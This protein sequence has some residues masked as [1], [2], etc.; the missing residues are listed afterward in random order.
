MK[1]TGFTMILL[2]IVGSFSSLSAQDVCPTMN[3]MKEGSCILIEYPSA[4]AASKA[5]AAPAEILV[6][7]ESSHEE[8]NGTYIAQSSCSGTEVIYTKAGPCNCS[9][10]DGTIAGTFNFIQSE[11]TCKY[12]AAGVLPVTFSYFTAEKERDMT[13]LKWA[14]QFESDNEGFYVEK[15][16]D[17]KF[18]QEFAFVV[19]E[20]NSSTEIDYDAV[21]R[22]PFS[23]LNYYRLKQVDYNGNERYSEIVQV[24]FRS[25]QSMTVNFNRNDEQLT[26]RSKK[27]LQSIE[28]FDMAGVRIYKDALKSNENQHFINLSG[29]K[30]GHF[31][32]VITDEVGNVETLK[33][34]K[35]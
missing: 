17:G 14:T 1:T 2:L 33:F 29:Q 19:G 11:M 4:D 10:Y 23:G 24:D 22:D 8:S 5:I 3:T 6:I 12:D 13:V 21:D 16:N 15:S 30:K 18:F 28:I 7:S 31:V 35:L 27:N 20:G 34:S 32:A 25:N 26:I 9:S